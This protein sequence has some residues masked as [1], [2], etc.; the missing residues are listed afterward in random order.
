ML[1]SGIIKT[2]LVQPF[3]DMVFDA[4]FVCLSEWGT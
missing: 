1:C 2:L 3:A 4:V